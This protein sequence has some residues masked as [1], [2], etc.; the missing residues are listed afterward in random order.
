MFVCF[1]QTCRQRYL[2][3]EKG[4]DYLGESFYCDQFAAI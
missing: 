4:H 3:A 1:L 2:T